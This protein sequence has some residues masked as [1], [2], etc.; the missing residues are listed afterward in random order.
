[1]FITMV[2]CPSETNCEFAS[3]VRACEI[4]HCLLLRRHFLLFMSLRIAK[5]RIKF[6]R[7][8][9]HRKNKMLTGTN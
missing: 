2:V 1:M 3:I 8:S 6:A 9:R 4:I 5:R 7:K